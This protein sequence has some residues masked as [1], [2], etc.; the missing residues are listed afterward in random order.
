VHAPRQLSL[1]PTHTLNAFIRHHPWITV[2]VSGTLA[3]TMYT[4]AAHAPLAEPI[5]ISPAAIDAR[6]PFLP[7]A[8]WLYATYLLVL[9]TLVLLA[10]RLAAFER[11][12]TAAM[13]TA[14][15]NAAIYIAW[16]TRLDMRTEAPAGTLLALIQQLD[17]TLCAL[18]SGHVS[19]PMAITTAALLV[20][21]GVNRPAARRW[22]LLS[23][24][25][26]VWTIVLAVSTLLTRQH[27]VVD[28]AAGA[29][30]GVLMGIFVAAR[31]FTS[32][33]GVPAPARPGRSSNRLDSAVGGCV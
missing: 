30:F 14:L 4:V 20:S 25:F 18:P 7:W 12:L 10:S 11:V 24:A 23:T 19:L 28:A 15:S 27:Y 5:V 32:P 16:P 13:T 21:L 2:A 29:A 31:R 9:P 6:V 17:T 1:S 33:V 26:F 8:A 22:Q 3:G